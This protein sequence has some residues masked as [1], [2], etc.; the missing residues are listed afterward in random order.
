MSPCVTRKAGGGRTVFTVPPQPPLPGQCFLQQQVN[1]SAPSEPQGSPIPPVGPAVPVA[2]PLGNVGGPHGPNLGVNPH[3][4]TTSSDLAPAEAPQSGAHS[5]LTSGSVSRSGHPAASESVHPGGSHPQQGAFNPHLS[6]HGL[7]PMACPQ[8]LDLVTVVPHAPAC[9]DPGLHSFWCSLSLQQRR[10]LLRLPKKDLFARVRSLYCS[11]CFSLVQL[12]YD[13]L[14]AYVASQMAAGR[15]GGCSGPPQCAICAA[16]HACFAG[17]SVSEDG[18]VTLTDDLLAAHP[19]GRFDQARTWDQSRE[20][21]FSCG[22]VCG[23]GWCKRPGVNKCKLHTGP[24]SP[25]DLLSYWSTLPEP[26]REALMTLDEETFLGELDVSMKL[27]L[28]ICKE[29]RSNV[30][31]AF[32]EL[33][34]GR[35][36]VGQANAATGLVLCEGH[37]LRAGEGRVRVEGPGEACLFEKAEEVQEQKVRSGTGWL[38]K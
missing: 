7:K 28:R 6:P 22:E 17:L 33:K 10:Q 12:Q 9:L 38:G 18:A 32:K 13:E 35:D 19:F 8:H 1:I 25:D 36:A 26:R 3:R 4:Q 14:C 37:E 24:V 21:H 2:H 16:G 15:N 31:R 29:C 30:T 27:Q 11:G 34:P 5:N 20:Q 23:S